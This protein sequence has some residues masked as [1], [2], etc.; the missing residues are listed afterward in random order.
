MKDGQYQYMFNIQALNYLN[1]VKA[2]ENI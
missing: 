1:G 2:N